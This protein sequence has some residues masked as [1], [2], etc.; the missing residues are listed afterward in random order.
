MFL[1]EVVQLEVALLDHNAQ[2]PAHHVAVA[3]YLEQFAAAHETMR[4][5]ATAQRR[6]AIGAVEV[7]WK[8]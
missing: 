8:R 6:T 4:A 1:V 5:E 3:E 7:D 2:P